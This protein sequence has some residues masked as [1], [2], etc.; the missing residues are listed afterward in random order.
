MKHSEAS[1]NNK[2]IRVRPYRPVRLRLT[3]A[4]RNVLKALVVS[5]VCAAS[6]AAPT[7]TSHLSHHMCCSCVNTILALSCTQVLRSQNLIH[8]SSIPSQAGLVPGA[9]PP[10]ILPRAALKR[11]LFPS[12]SGHGVRAVLQ[13]K[14]LWVHLEGP[15]K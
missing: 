9:V 13:P 1:K 4:T 10:T 6:H 14:E 15:T 5:W 7:P 3:S 11:K 8:Q 2:K 12:L